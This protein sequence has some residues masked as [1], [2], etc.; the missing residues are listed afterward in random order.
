MGL[1]YAAAVRLRL[2]FTSADEAKESDA[3]RKRSVWTRLS[4]PQP[5]SPLA[6]TPARAAENIA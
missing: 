6:G 2:T 3:N 5:S 4:E 1:R